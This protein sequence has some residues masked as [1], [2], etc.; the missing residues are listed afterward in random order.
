M[1][2]SFY[3]FHVSTPSTSLSLQ[4]RAKRTAGLRQARISGLTYQPVLEDGRRL[5][6]LPPR[7]QGVD[8]R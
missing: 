8:I 6:D 4:Q 2:H 1:Q 7:L 5:D 3:S